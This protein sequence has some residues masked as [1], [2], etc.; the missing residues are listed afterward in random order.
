[1]T[2]HKAER[3]FV[4]NDDT[5]KFVFVQKINIDFNQ[6]SDEEDFYEN[7]GLEYEEFFYNA[8]DYDEETTRKET[9]E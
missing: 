7:E 3:G 6:S 5:G 1:M 8:I 2:Q 4:R 9:F